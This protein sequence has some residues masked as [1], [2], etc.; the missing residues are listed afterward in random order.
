MK[1]L[2]SSTSASAAPR[3][4]GHEIHPPDSPGRVTAAHPVAGYAGSSGGAC[5]TG[6]ACQV[7]RAAPGACRRWR[8]RPCHGGPSMQVVVA[9][10]RPHVVTRADAQKVTVLRGNPLCHR[11]RPGA[12]RDSPGRRHRHHGDR[13]ARYATG[14][15]GPAPLSAEPSGPAAGP[16]HRRCPCGV[17]AAADLTPP[18]AVPP[19]HR[20]HGSG[21]PGPAGPRRLRAA[22]GAV[23]PVRRSVHVWSGIVA[24]VPVT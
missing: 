22:A 1:W 8:A 24:P 7:G 10:P 15:Q 9:I 13:P 19:C 6:T 2:G 18:P 5:P 4:P 11:G 14:R 21:L 3:P 12:E 20:T 17:T 23:G 16:T